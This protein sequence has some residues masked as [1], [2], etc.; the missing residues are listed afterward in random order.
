MEQFCLDT[1]GD[2]SNAICS[3]SFLR[4][5]TQ[6]GWKY[7]DLRNLN[8]FFAVKYKEMIENGEIEETDGCLD[9]DQMA[10][11]DFF[12]TEDDGMTKQ[13]QPAPVDLGKIIQEE[14]ESDQDDNRKKPD[15]SLKTKKTMVSV[16]KLLK[17]SKN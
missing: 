4:S 17:S 12:R 11:D 6:N 10:D 8:E 13:T 3:Q 5:I 16:I 1:F 2:Y 9:E 14:D 7:F 15:E